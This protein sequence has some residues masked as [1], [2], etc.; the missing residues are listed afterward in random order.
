MVN[1]SG[2]SSLA[3]IKTAI[4][5]FG[6][7]GLQRLARKRKS[8]RSIKR[9]GKKVKGITRKTFGLT[10]RTLKRIVKLPINT[11]KRASK[12]VRRTKKRRSRKARKSNRKR[13]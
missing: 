1:K 4:V 2:G 13:R 3:A 7:W 10:R 6:L 11:L 8:R 12:I 9:V 5:P